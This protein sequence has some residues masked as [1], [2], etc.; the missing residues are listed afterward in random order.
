MQLN[1][2]GIIDFKSI[3]NNI[4]RRETSCTKCRKK[5]FFSI[6]D[7][8]LLYFSC[9]IIQNL[10]FL[11]PYKGILTLLL[12]SADKIVLCLAKCIYNFKTQGKK[13]I[14]QYSSQMIPF[15]QV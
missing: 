5:A 14:E 9:W 1:Y 7:G 11:T 15:L 8:K 13:E 2:T 3:E 6:K 4:Q 12:D 10:Q